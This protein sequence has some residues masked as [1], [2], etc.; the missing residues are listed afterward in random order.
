MKIAIIITTYW[1]LDG[2]TRAEL[3]RALMS[4][5]NQT[6]QDYKVFLIGDDY[7]KEDELFELAKIIDEDKIYVENL[8]VA[9]ERIKYSGRDLWACGGDNATRTGIRKAMEEGFDYVAEL[10]HDDYYFPNHIEVVVQAIKETGANF[11]IT[12]C[13][14]MPDNLKPT[15]LY[16]PYRP[17]AGHLFTVSAC[18]NQRYYNIYRKEA[19]ERR[20]GPKNAIYAGDASKWDRT[21]KIMKDRHEW[22][23]FVNI[24]TCV[25][26][27]SGKLPIIKPEIVKK[28]EDGTGGI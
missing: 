7:E 18:Y 13:G 22:G 28:Q 27:A 9:V 23:V 17:K 6:C 20:G 3:E 10:N 11:V 2:S 15:G 24:K 5:K 19:E 8:P 25:K 16:T 12:K 14:S 4:V 21:V 1:K 26:S